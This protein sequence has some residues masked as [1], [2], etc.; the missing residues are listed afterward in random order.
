MKNKR[1]ILAVFAIT[2]FSNLITAQIRVNSLFND[3]MVLQRDVDI[4]VW[5]TASVNESVTVLLNGKSVVVQA[6]GKGNWIAKLPKQKA[7]GPYKMEI[8]GKNR[9][10]YNDVYVGDVWLC[11]GQSNM[12]MTVAKETR[13][14]CGVINEAEEVTNAKYPLI[15]F[16]DVPYT[17]SQTV[18]LDVVGKWEVC[19]PETIGHQSAVAYFFAREI[20]KKYK[21]PVGLLTSSFGASTAETWISKEALEAQPNLKPLLD[22]YAAKIDKFVSD[23]TVTMSKYRN[24]LAKFE[25]DL[26]VAQAAAGDVTAKATKAPKSPKNPDPAS[27]QHNPYVCYNGMIAPLA[28]YAI[29][30]ALWYQ[31]ESNGPS[32]KLYREI[33]ETLITDWRSKF[34]VGDFP[35]LYVQ[36]A[37][38]GKPMQK[39]VEDGSMM[40][41]REAQLQ[42]L[43]VKNTGMAVAIENAGDEP[44]NIHPKNKQAIGYRLGLIARAKGYGE[45]VAYSGPIYKNYVIKDNTVELSFDHLGKGL[46]AKDN[47]LTGFAICGEDKKWVTA[48]AEI[49]GEKVIVS[50][51]EVAKP[52]AVRYAWGTNPP[53]S[54]LNK[55]GL[56]APNFRTDN[57]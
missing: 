35:F 7:G 50:S 20:Y 33:M 19:S 55:D 56:W 51:T 40:T 8:S 13:Y 22:T 5:G 37:N 28:P 15:R 46:V 53:A 36:L 16:F 21:I 23:S 38:Y 49:K 11:G 52:V 32:A 44:N 48:N 41:I 26:A 4:P 14:W 57:W 45:K 1:W 43:S 9:M 25:G 6:D 27:D 12:H 2:V 18:K 39:P 30:G 47:K 42:N 3:H 24:E 54:L 34:Q 10:V 17:P 31:G 29:K